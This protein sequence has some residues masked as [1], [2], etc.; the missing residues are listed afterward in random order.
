MLAG[1]TESKITPVIA[2]IHEI[3]PNLKAKFVQLDLGS[4]KS[5]HSAATEIS[6]AVEKIDILINN[7]GIMACPYAKSEEGIEIQFA[8]NHIGHFLLTKLL[9]D[10]IYAAGPG[11]RIVNVSSSA[12]RGSIRFDDYNFQVRLQNQNSSPMHWLTQSPGWCSV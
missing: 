3:N 4:Q 6:A 11:A 10:K 2:Q 7:A 5:V 1:R 12:L 8:T 9:I